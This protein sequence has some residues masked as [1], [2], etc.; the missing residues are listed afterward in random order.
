MTN[1]RRIVLAA[2]VSAALTAGSAR[3]VTVC[4]GPNAVWGIDVSEFQGN[5]NW[6]A[7]KA[8]GKEFAIIRVS[9]GT[10][11]Y[12]PTFTQNWQGAKSAGVIRGAYQFFEP[13]EDAVAQ[14]NLLLSHMTGFGQGDLPPMI[15]VEVTGGQSPATITAKIHQW[16]DTIQAATGRKPLIYTGGWFW[17]PDVQTSDFASY[18]LVDSYYCSSCCPNIAAGWSSWAMWQYSST[19]A[20]GGIAGHVDLDRFDGTMA[21]LQKLAGGSVEWAASYVSQSWPLASTALTMTVNQTVAADLVMKNTGAKA[22]SDKTRLGTTQP[23]DRA[24]AFA[25]ASWMGPNRAA[26]CSGG[27]APGANCKFAFTFTAPNKPGDYHEFFGMVDEGVAWFSDNGQGGPP[28]NDLEAWIHVNE[29]DY[30]GEVTKLSYSGDVKLV[31]GDQVAGFVELKNV[32]N[33]PW[34][35]GVTKLAPTPHDKDSAVAGSDWLSASRAATLA[36]DVAPGQVG[37]FSLSLRGNQQGDFTQAFT[38]VEEAVT[39]FGDAPKGGG[40]GDEA[41]KVHVLVA[42][43]S[44]PPPPPPSVDGGAGP[45]VDS[46][47]VDNPGNNPGVDAGA[48]HPGVDAGHPSVDAGAHGGGHPGVDSGAL[49]SGSLDSGCSIGGRAPSSTALALV[50]AALALL[51]LRRRPRA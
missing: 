36:A 29:A 12:D 11:H 31:V 13:G 30:H 21:D 38:L 6:G 48:G 39:W 49:P 37:H 44:T 26:G 40:P 33:Q 20:V 18:P 22:W 51:L 46:G 45:S 27:A 32:G 2:V 25:D 4:P 42:A 35:A 14:A 7:V 41:I 8:D 15:D 34:K 43:A 47:N 3:A 17:N 9:D 19:G 5:I 28:D 10:Q 24:S 1:P 50:L 23:R 16:I